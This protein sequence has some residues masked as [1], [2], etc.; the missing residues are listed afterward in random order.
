MYTKYLATRPVIQ[1]PILRLHVQS[2]HLVPLHPDPCPSLLL[3]RIL[4]TLI[5]RFAL[6]KDHE[7]PPWLSLSIDMAS[8]QKNRL[9]LLHTLRRS[10]LLNLKLIQPP[11]TIITMWILTPSWWITAIVRGHLVTTVNLLSTKW[12]RSLVH[13]GRPL[14]R[15]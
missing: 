8:F 7:L 11:S 2:K 14:L 9:Q 3:H 5:L 15:G 13:R 1:V 6:P 10:Q 12:I 4:T